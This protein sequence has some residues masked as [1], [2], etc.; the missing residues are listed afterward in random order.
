MIVKGFVFDFDG[1]ILD[2]EGPEYLAWVEIFKDY[3]VDFPITE[4][5]KCVGSS[6]DTFNPY[7]YLESLVGRPVDRVSIKQRQNQRSD[8]LIEGMPPLPGVV[9]YLDYA[10][11]NGIKLAV[12][13]SSNRQWVTSHLSSLGLL[14]RFDAVLTR[15][16]V[17]NVKPDPELYLAAANALGIQPDEAVAFEDSPNGIT[18]AQKA[19]LFCVAVPNA[20][21]RALFTDHADLI[22]DSLSDLPPRILIQRVDGKM[23]VS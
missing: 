8:S 14:D 23:A 4:W 22:L 7:S 10:R 17:Q 19:G 13:S 1:L 21:T 12:A 16:E 20:I 2:T 18:A 5:G 6:F 9:E 11:E 15:D 3:N